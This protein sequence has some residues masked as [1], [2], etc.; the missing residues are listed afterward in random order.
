MEAR[1][2]LSTIGDAPPTVAELDA[3][4]SSAIQTRPNDS[5]TGPLDTFFDLS[6]SPDRVLAGAGLEFEVFGN[7]LSINAIEM[8]VTAT[9]TFSGG[10][11]FPD[12]PDGGGRLEPGG[13]QSDFGSGVRIR[14]SGNV[15]TIDHRSS[16]EFGI[17][18]TIKVRP[19]GT[20]DG[21]ITCTATFDLGGATVGPLRV[22]AA[23]VGTAVGSY[24]GDGTT[25][26]ALFNAPEPAQGVTGAFDLQPSGGGSS[27]TVDLGM[28]GDIPVTGD[29][30]GDGTADEAVF[31]PN[32]DSDADGTADSALW[33]IRQSSDGDV[34]QVRFGA[35]TDLPVPADYDGDGTTEVATFRPDSDLTAG[36]S[37]WF[38][39]PSSGATAY[40]TPFG[41]PRDDD[42]V[43]ADYDGDGK[44]DLAT[45][46]SESDLTDDSAEWF[47][48][49]SSGAASYRVALGDV[50]TVAA[51]GYYEGTVLV[52]LAAYDPGTTTWTIRDG[53][54]SAVRTVDF[55]SSRSVPVLAPLADRIRF[56]LDTAPAPNATTAAA[57]L[58]DPADADGGDAT[59]GAR[60]DHALEDLDGLGVG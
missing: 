24:E 8:N 59:P 46:R 47:I 1:T 25:D 56:A 13:F 38:I 50:G 12:L 55:G 51:P 40:R 6:V 48:L 35:P 16:R 17:L 43:P 3:V 37:E 29:F 31:R 26:L 2:L 36:A 27:R 22:T 21:P 10:V 54:S 53:G 15:V 32:V 18:S 60:V 58:P 14:R 20:S 4:G 45:F 33:I 9:L 5:T 19:T 23:V 49:P 11:D 34:R 39:L 57:S 30:D 52:G 41:S 28:P 42:P 7:Q 44:A